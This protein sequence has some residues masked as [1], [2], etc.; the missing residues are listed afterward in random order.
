MCIFKLKAKVEK[1]SEKQL[2]SSI[3]KDPYQLGILFDTYYLPIFNYV[4]RRIGNYDTAKD[5]CSETFLKAFLN[6][7]RFQW[8]GIPISFWLYRI[9]N[10]EVQ[11]CFRNEKYIPGSLDLLIETKGWDVVDSASTLE[12]KL[13]LIS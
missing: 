12:H 4:F 9:A 6:I 13:Q 1:E 3:Q 8:K 10:N 11:Q 2:I 7:G 5:V